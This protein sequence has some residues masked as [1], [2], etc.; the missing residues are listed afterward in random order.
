M[1]ELF[2]AVV[3][4]LWVITLYILLPLAIIAGLIYLMIFEFAFFAALLI[5]FIFLWMLSQGEDFTY[6]Q[7]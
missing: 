3:K 7:H 1:G 5:C 6:K 2:T 4:L